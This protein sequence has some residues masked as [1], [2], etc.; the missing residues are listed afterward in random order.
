VTQSTLSLAILG[1]I[2]LEPS[3]GYDLR[4]IFTTTPMGHFSTSPGAIY[5]A[6]RRMERRGLIEGS[7]ERGDTLRP[8]RIYSVTREGRRVLRE[9]LSQHV[10]NDDVRWRL[11]ELMLRFSFMG[12]IVGK[13][14]SSEFLAELV[15]RIDAHVRSLKE[16]LDAQRDRMPVTGVYAL[17]QGIV[18]YE[19]TARWARR[20]LRELRKKQLMKNM[21]GKG[22]ESTLS[23]NRIEW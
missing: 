9:R 13:E 12:E 10:T 17:E 5:P 7:I 16:H 3:S 19:A 20:V 8:R 14:R 4:R 21:R 2:A 22:T 15:E 1:L 11:D 23:N 18:K 6:L